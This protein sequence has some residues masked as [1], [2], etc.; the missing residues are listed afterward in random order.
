MADTLRIACP[1]CGSQRIAK[2]FGLDIIDGAFAVLDDV[3]V[4]DPLACVITIGGRA[5]CSWGEP[6]VP[7]P[8]ALRVIRDRLAT[9]LARADALLALA[10]DD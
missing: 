3:P 2:A 9:A 8:H 7:P 5:R 1:V 10:D 6:F 4:R